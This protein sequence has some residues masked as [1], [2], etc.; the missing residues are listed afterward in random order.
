MYFLVSKVSIY[1]DIKSLDLNIDFLFKM[2]R[3]Y[4]L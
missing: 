3:S 4:N 1:D 2:S